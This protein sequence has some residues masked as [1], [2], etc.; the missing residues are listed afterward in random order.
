M[1]SRSIFFA[2]LAVLLPLCL[3]AQVIEGRVFDAANN[4]PLA[5]ATIISQGIAGG[6]ITDQ[7]GYFKWEST[8]AI[9]IIEVSYIGYEPRSIII[10]DNKYLNIGLITANTELQEIVVSAYRNGQ[11]YQD[12]P[13]AI[14]LITPKDLQRSEAVIITPALN[15]IP[16]VYMH[17]GALNTNRITIR[18]IGSRSPFSTTK[19]RAYLNDIPLTTGTGETTIEDIDLGIVDRVEVIKGPSSSIYGAGLGGTINYTVRKAPYRQTSIGLGTKAGSYG[20]LSNTVS[21]SHGSDL[22]N[23]NFVMNDLHSD[24]YR[25]NNEYD[26]RTYNISG[27]LYA[28]KK[29]VLTFI[30]NWIDLKAFIPS[31]IDSATF[32]EDPTSAAFTWQQVEGFE[33]YSKSLYGLNYLQDINQNWMVSTSLFTSRRESFEL[34]PFNTL[35]DKARASGIRAFVGYGRETGL[36][37]NFSFGGEYFDENYDWRTLRNFSDTL[38][39]DNEEVRR[40]YN[41]FSQLDLR[42]SERTALVL[43]LNLNNTSYE[44]TDLFNPDSL[45]TSGEYSFKTELSPRI[46]FTHKF[47]QNHTLFG[48]ISHGFSPPT[49]EETLTP[50]GQVNPEIKPETGYNFEIGLRGRILTDRLFYDASV[51]T[52]LIENLLVAERVQD[53]IYVG[54]NAGKTVHLGLDLSLNYNLLTGLNNLWSSA[55][56]FATYMFADYSFKEFINEDNDYSGNELTGTPGNKLNMGL[57]FDM[58]VGIYG[59]LEYQFVDEMPMNDAN[60]KYS[61]SYSLLNF[62]LGWSRSFGNKERLFLDVY[63]AVNNIL[64]EKYASMIAV[65]APSFGGRA[66]RYYYPGLPRN[67]FGG[68]ELVYRF[69]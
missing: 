10:G 58:N 16:G 47:D 32:A 43:G 61:D 59:F 6:A 57:D 27:Q 12:T 48:N 50:E 7:N 64:D 3:D 23:L 9:E 20:L 14:A 26:R 62:K 69:K 56:V 8:E 34:R 33:D 25:D 19:I 65:N 54:V 42:L 39:S 22:G 18:G 68:V 40:Y 45:S 13:G 17:S 30:A 35:E 51:Y 52:M 38:L 67:Y 11:R 36:I 63:A 5:G 28:G 37:S 41:V 2:F 44:I 49:L 29:G 24:G 46:A 31:S 4:M 21:V 53:D 66:P 15:R 1:K 60:T 55:T